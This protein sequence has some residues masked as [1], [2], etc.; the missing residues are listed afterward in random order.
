MNLRSWI[1]VSA[2]ALGAAS[3][4]AQPEAQAA[5]YL[6]EA[7]TEAQA[8]QI[9]AYRDSNPEN[10]VLLPRRRLV[11]YL[12]LNAFELVT[13]SDLHFESNLRFFADFGLSKNEAAL[14]DGTRSS[15]ADLLYAH[16]NYRRGGFGLRVG[17]QVY[18]DMMDIMAF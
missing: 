7:R 11:Q 10:P 5:A 17:R 6:V 15:D 1:Q 16:I 9:R 12:S 18:A 4:W 13:G 14:V 3:L 2:C 8:Y